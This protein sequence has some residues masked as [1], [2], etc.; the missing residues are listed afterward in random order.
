MRLRWLL[1]I[2]IT[3][4]SCSP[5]NNELN[6]TAIQKESLALH[7]GEALFNAYCN[8][9]HNDVAME[10]AR[11]APPMLAIK[12]RYQNA[13]TDSTTF[14]KAIIDFVSHPTQEKALMSNA[15]QKF[16]LMLPMEYPEQ[17]LVQIADYIA[18]HTFKH[19]SDRPLT[20]PIDLE[21]MT[22]MEKGQYFASSTKAVLGKQLM[23][24]IHED[25]TLG[26]LAF[27]NLHAVH[28]TDSMSI[29][30]H[31]AIKR[32]TDRARNAEN[33]ANLAEAEIIDTWKQVLSAGK[34]IEPLLESNADGSFNFYAPILTNAMCL[35]CHG[36]LDDIQPEVKNA[37]QQ[38]YPADHATGYGSGELR[39]IWSI[40]WP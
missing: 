19:P 9:C 14:T 34:K 20:A 35:Q 33:K 17:D 2:V 11:L 38:L 16:N 4:L 10:D 39:G 3:F 36:T 1:F 31:V 15:L 25:G 6:N 37:L 18:K 22:A 21:S 32:V 30:H 28:Y 23:G 26:A 29:K 7:P 5:A 12:Q 27:C 24:K 13:Y 40:H 8:S